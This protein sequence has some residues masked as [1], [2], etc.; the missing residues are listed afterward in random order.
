MAQ[1]K[2]N[3]KNNDASTGSISSTTH[4]AAIKKPVVKKKTTAQ[5]KKN[6][7]KK[8][9]MDYLDH[10]YAQIESEIKKYWPWASLRYK[11][12]NG[13]GDG[14][15]SKYNDK[16]VEFSLVFNELHAYAISWTPVMMNQALIAIK[17]DP[18]PFRKN[19]TTRLKW[20]D[21]FEELKKLDDVI[22]SNFVDVPSS[23]I[24]TIQIMCFNPQLVQA[25]DMLIQDVIQKENEEYIDRMRRNELTDM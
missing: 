23:N 18:I 5:K 4:A 20:A 12:S 17:S 24:S 3:K 21:T 14:V 10:V 9:Q 11:N 19:F 13:L 22:L 15:T 8:Q 16:T 6:P 1:S 7:V 2:K 25:I